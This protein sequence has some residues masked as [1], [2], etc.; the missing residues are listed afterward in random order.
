MVHCP[1]TEQGWERV[2]EEE[3]TASSE[4]K[5]VPGSCESLSLLMKFRGGQGRQEELRL[6]RCPKPYQRAHGEGGMQLPL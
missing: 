3:G 4:C 1:G 6:L 2:Q 5:L